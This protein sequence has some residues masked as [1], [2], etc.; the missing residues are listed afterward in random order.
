MTWS[1]SFF[2]RKAQ[3]SKKETFG[4]KFSMEPKRL[5][6]MRQ[7]EDKMLDLVQNVQTKTVNFNEKLKKIL[8]KFRVIIVSL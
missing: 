3:P 7:F 2:L 4:F 5:P 1:A 8:K 6:E